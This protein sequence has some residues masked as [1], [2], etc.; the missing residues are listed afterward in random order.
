MV[1]GDPTPDGNSLCHLRRAWKLAAFAKPSG[2]LC[3]QTLLGQP[4]TLS[5]EPE[6]PHARRRLLRTRANHPAK[7]RKDQTRHNQE[8]TL[9][10]SKDSTCRQFRQFRLFVRANIGGALSTSIVLSVT[11]QMPKSTFRAQRLRKNQSADRESVAAAVVSIAR[12]QSA[13]ATHTDLPRVKSRIPQLL[14]TKQVCK[15]LPFD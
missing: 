9:A 3:R 15:F 12:R 14:C 6:K 13:K 10:A 8:P 2:P 4:P 7:T 1:A 5:R 11:S